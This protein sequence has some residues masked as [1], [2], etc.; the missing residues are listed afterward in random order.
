MSGAHRLG[1]VLFLVSAVLFAISAIRSG[2]VLVLVA[3][4]VFGGACVLFLLPER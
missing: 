2:D 4:V 3:S 1:W